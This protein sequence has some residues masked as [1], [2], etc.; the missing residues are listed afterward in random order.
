MNESTCVG[1]MLDLELTSLNLGLCSPNFAQRWGN[2][3]WNQRA[4]TEA[5]DQAPKTDP[6]D[7]PWFLAQP[8]KLWRL[9]RVIFYMNQ[10]VLSVLNISRVGWSTGRSTGRSSSSEGSRSAKRDGFAVGSRM[11][12][13]GSSICNQTIFFEIV[14]DR[15]AHLPA[16]H[17]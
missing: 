14:A 2:V 12:G 16:D 8:F 9:R 5:A 1:V 11:G 15:P 17:F 10:S 3:F 6:R 7:H 4:R 13:I